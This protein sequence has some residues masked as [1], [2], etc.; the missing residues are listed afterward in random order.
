ML[1]EDHGVSQTSLLWS[2]L[3]AR[4]FIEI[5]HASRMTVCGSPPRLQL[6]ELNTTILLHSFG[7]SVSYHNPVH[8]LSLKLHIGGRCLYLASTAPPYP[9][10]DTSSTFL[11]KPPRIVGYHPQLLPPGITGEGFKMGQPIPQLSDPLPAL[12]KP[13]TLSH[14]PLGP[15][16]SFATILPVA[17]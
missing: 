8:M 2:P 10:L 17:M 7:L 3:P 12:G 4:Y 13:P 16:S 15:P 11:S 9:A 14:L 5:P 1:R 6:G